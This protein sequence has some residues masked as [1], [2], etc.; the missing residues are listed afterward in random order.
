MGACKLPCCD[1]DMNNPSAPY[2]LDSLS[3]LPPDQRRQAVHAVLLRVWETPGV[4][5]HEI[6]PTQALIAVAVVAASLP[7]A[8]WRPWLDDRL[9]AAALP[10][11]SGALIGRALSALDVLVGRDPESVPLELHVSDGEA[12]RELLDDLRDVLMDGIRQSG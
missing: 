6:P 12:A 4:L 1:D 11:V 8:Y 7:A 9:I 3:K 2:L 10:E 5:L